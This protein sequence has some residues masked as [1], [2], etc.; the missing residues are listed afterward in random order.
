MPFV[1]SSMSN[2]TLADISELEELARK[3]LPISTYD[4]FAGGAD[5]EETLRDSV[6]AWRHLSLRPH[7]LRDVSDVTTATS[8]LGSSFASP[9][10]V[11][12]MAFQ[13]LV[14]PEGEI[15]MAR[16]VAGAQML[17]T[18]SSRASMEL[19]R[20][21]AAAPTAPKW[22]QIYIMRDR[23]RTLDLV[24]EA[25]ATGFTAIVLTVD[26]PVVARRMRDVVN[27]FSRPDCISSGP[28][29]ELTELRDGA[30]A[31]DPA[32]SV[33][34]IAWLR[35]AS[36]L[37]IV[38]KGVVRGD[39][40]IRCVDAGASAIW[41]SA[42]GGRQLD[43]CI[44]TPAA[45]IDVAD[46]VSSRCEVYVDGGIRRGVDVLRALALG[47]NAAF[48]GRPAIWALVHGGAQTVTTVLQQIDA[49]LKL[50]MALCGARD[51]SELTRDLV[52]MPK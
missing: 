10:G 49:E 27:G 3:V 44:A 1:M 11:A 32:M 29:R 46:A 2:A 4:F 40:A 5:D 21:G 16:G 42:H 34:D 33:D 39:D 30:S 37:P 13:G 8:I 41:V 50:A 6:V 15:G 43:G 12:P 9:I 25:K 14:H 48:I 28:R 35:D 22:F 7:V 24:L 52:A 47:A 45:L 23:A 18:I 31:Q 38:V 20:I 36:G 26:M 17:V 19:A 51:L